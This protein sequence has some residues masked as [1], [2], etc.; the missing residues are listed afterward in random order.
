[1]LGAFYAYGMLVIVP[2]DEFI[3]IADVFALP[4]EQIFLRG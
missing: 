4:V 1:M 2:K 3:R